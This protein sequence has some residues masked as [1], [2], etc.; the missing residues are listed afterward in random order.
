M[1]QVG[2]AQVGAGEVGAGEVGPLGIAAAKVS[3]REL[4]LA[5]VGAFQFGATEARAAEVFAGQ[6][7]AGEVAVR[8][9]GGRLGCVAVPGG[10]I[11]GRADVIGGGS[12][13][14]NRILVHVRCDSDVVVISEHDI[15][16]GIALGPAEAASS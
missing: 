6:V 1:K 14:T 8:Q 9:I 15:L 2:L 16:D 5:Q 4:G 7:L 13:I 11:S 3:P 10:Q 12:L